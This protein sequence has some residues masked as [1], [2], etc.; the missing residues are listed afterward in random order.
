[1]Y[2]YYYSVLLLDDIA[3]SISD[4]TY[5]NRCICTW[6]VCL[7]PHMLS[8]TLVYA[9]KAV[10]RNE[11]PF[12]R[13]TCVAPGNIT[14]DRGPRPPCEGEIWGSERPKHHNQSAT[15]NSKH[16]YSYTPDVTTVTVMPPITKLLC[17]PLLLF[18]YYPPP[19]GVR[20][21]V[22]GRFLSFC[23]FVSNIT[24]KWLDRFA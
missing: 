10:G 2:Y 15:T 11:M 6:S 7:S 3:D 13:D 4:F 21:I 17:W 14:L 12:G 20:G 16:L 22:F 24:R 1:M 8:I 5:C 19:V 23:L 9:A 18:Y